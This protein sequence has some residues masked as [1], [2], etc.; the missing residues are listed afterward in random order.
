MFNVIREDEWDLKPLKQIKHEITVASH[1]FQ[2]TKTQGSAHNDFINTPG[3]EPLI[4]ICDN[5]FRFYIFKGD[6]AM[7]INSTSELIIIVTINV[8][9]FIQFNKLTTKSCSH[10]FF[11]DMSGNWGCS[12]GT[13]CDVGTKVGA[14]ILSVHFTRANVMRGPSVS[15]S[16]V[17][18]HGGIGGV[19]LISSRNSSGE[20]A[21]SNL[22]SWEA[23]AIGSGKG[24][25]AVKINTVV[26]EWSSD[27]DGGIAADNVRITRSTGDIRITGSTGDIMG[28][29][30]ATMMTSWRDTNYVR[31]SYGDTM[32]RGVDI[33]RCV[34]CTG[35][36]CR[37][38]PGEAG[39]S[40]GTNLRTGYPVR[41][42]D[43]ST[44]M[45]FISNYPGASITEVRMMQCWRWNV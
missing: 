8:Q 35:H 17:M 27:S 33:T 45:I 30:V 3:F 31:W 1:F 39:G 28:H 11:I 42:R 10:Y 4:C 18:K 44:S 41:S 9:A 22:G 2:H 34:G 25:A 16:H 7:R 21:V 37:V 14:D 15:T 19:S 29:V 6:I 20:V 43:A 36:R 23:R 5:S 13:C 38:G 32:C 12:V 26:G 24:V 40:A